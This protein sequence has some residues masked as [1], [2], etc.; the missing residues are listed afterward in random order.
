M[1]SLCVITELLNRALVWDFSSG[2]QDAG[3]SL[4]LCSWVLAR[5]GL[6]YTV[7]YPFPQS[8]NY[9]SKD[10]RVNKQQL[11]ADFPF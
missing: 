3:Y 4:R 1:R 9:R 8:Y 10:A 11:T 7:L 5:M 2:S 6:S